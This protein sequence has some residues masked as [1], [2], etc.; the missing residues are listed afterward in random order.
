M[1]NINPNLAMKQ[2]CE[3][4]IVVKLEGFCISYF[5][6]LMHTI[7]CNRNMRPLK[8]WW[9]FSEHKLSQLTK[10]LFSPEQAS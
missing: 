8:T 4:N 3:N 7:S 9:I 6:T 10:W 5:A 1:Q 2:C